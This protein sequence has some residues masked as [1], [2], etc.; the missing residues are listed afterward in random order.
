MQVAENYYNEEHGGVVREI[1]NAS[2]LE[3]IMF[4]H[5]TDKINRKKIGDTAAFYIVKSK[6]VRR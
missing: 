4:W 1:T 3:K 6:G 5:K 2:I